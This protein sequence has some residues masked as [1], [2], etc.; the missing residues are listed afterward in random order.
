MRIRL[1]G[2]FEL[3]HGRRTARKT[4]AVELMILDMQACLQISNGSNS[5][6][7]RMPYSEKRPAGAVRT[8]AWLSS[9]FIAS[10][11]V[12]SD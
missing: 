1:Q 6:I 3:P 9:S 4:N 11:L 5:D 10:L 8:A 2:G 12:D 7:W